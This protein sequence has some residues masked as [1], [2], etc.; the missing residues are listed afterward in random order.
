VGAAQV[1]LPGREGRF[2]V[3]GSHR[4]RLEYGPP[5]GV[6]PDGTLVIDVSLRTGLLEVTR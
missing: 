1:D 2:T 4:S 6:R 5:D 3:R